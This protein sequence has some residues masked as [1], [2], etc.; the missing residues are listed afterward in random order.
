V[1]EALGSIPILGAY[2]LGQLLRKNQTAAPEILNQGIEIVLL[3]A[4]E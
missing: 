1:Q 3:G 4:A 2:T